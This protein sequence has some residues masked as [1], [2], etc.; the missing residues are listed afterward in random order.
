M[1]V[2]PFSLEQYLLP[3]GD[4]KLKQQPFI[5]LSGRAGFILPPMWS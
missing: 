4:L 1:F 2:K 3:P 5:L